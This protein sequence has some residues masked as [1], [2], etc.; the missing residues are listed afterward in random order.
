MVTMAA[1]VLTIALSKDA[2]IAVRLPLSGP[3]N[4][5]TS[6][7]TNTTVKSWNR[8]TEKVA[9]PCPI[10]RIHLCRQSTC[11]ATAVEE[12]A[13]PKPTMTAGGTIRPHATAMAAPTAVDSII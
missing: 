3:A 10:R 9:R 6:M 7:N 5:G 1:L 11:M 4:S 12:N 8:S 13:R 2:P